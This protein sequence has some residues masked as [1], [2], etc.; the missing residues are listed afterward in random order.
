[1]ST[2]DN[3]SLQFYAADGTPLPAAVSREHLLDLARGAYERGG[4]HLERGDVDIEL[5]EAADKAAC[6]LLRDRWNDDFPIAAYVELL[7][8]VAALRAVLGFDPTPTAR[9]VLD[10]AEKLGERLGSEL[11]GPT[12]PFFV[13]FANGPYRGAVLSVP[14]TL[15][16]PNM[17][18]AGTLTLPI[19]WGDTLDPGRGEARY[20]RD[21]AADEGLWLY[22]LDGDVRE[23]ARPHITLPAASDQVGA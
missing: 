3:L 14:G 16:M 2:T 20:Q 22:R 10:W 12:S 15:V 13:K 18:P 17:G 8:T 1:M 7:T 4:T 21:A 6:S 23:D 19:A 9:E 11:E 5:A